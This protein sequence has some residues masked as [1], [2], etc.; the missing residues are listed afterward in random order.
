M[1]VVTNENLSEVYP[2]MKEQIK[3]C[4]FVA[5]DCEFSG[6]RHRD[7]LYPRTSTKDT[8]QQI[9][10]RYR[11]VGQKY[12]LF[13]VGLSF[14]TFNKERNLFEEKTY[15]V[16]IHPDGQVPRMFQMDCL[17]F[18][19]KYHYD[20]EK[21]FSNGINGV[22]VA[23]EPANRAA[24]FSD[25]YIE[26][27]YELYR[28]RELTK[29]QYVKNVT[30]KHYSKAVVEKGKKWVELISE[31][32]G[33][34]N[35]DKED[36]AHK[37]RMTI[38]LDSKSEQ[39][40]AKEPQ[41]LFAFFLKDHDLTAIVNAKASTMEISKLKKK[42]KHHHHP[43]G[44][45]GNHVTLESKESYLVEQL[46]FSI[47]FVELLRAKKPIV[48]HYCIFDWFYLYVYFIHDLPFKI[49]DWTASMQRYF[50]Y[51][52]DTKILAKSVSTGVTGLSTIVELYLK[53]GPHAL[54]EATGGVIDTKMFDIEMKH[55]AGYD[56]FI[57]GYAFLNLALQSIS[58]VNFKKLKSFD[59]STIPGF[60]E[61]LA[62]Q[63][64]H[65]ILHFSSVELNFREP[66]NDK[67][68][69]DR[70]RNTTLMLYF[71]DKTTTTFTRM[72][73]LN[74]I[75]NFLEERACFELEAINGLGIYLSIIENYEEPV[76]VDLV[77]LKTDIEAKFGEF[78]QA[79]LQDE[80]K[81]F[82]LHEL[83]FHD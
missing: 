74:D 14:F 71:N 28:K 22:K 10:E 69:R 37:S 49:E 4:D 7:E 39:L 15:S 56:A 76:M 83:G 68:R 12:H 24:I 64:L 13:Q 54:N 50:P 25:D 40:Y 61:K 52:Y 11:Y 38:E 20:F 55:D 27:L 79:L 70:F 62:K 19:S 35:E 82:D 32:F 3:S 41:S 81:T 5:F 34:P 77:A 1:Q 75:R 60:L 78:V 29:K 6:L 2:E 57:T 47:A 80:W 44:P 66:T 73:I 58:D 36:P 72:N 31:A 18:L 67:E 33:L 26:Q 16:L 46:G 59:N 42:L 43:G 45:E 48:G 65:N 8:N 9:F 51:V 63:E 53:R 30:H 17:T 23:D 21:T